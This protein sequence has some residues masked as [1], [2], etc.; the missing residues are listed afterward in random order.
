M[1]IAKTD[2][3]VP[4]EMPCFELY[5][6]YYSLLIKRINFYDSASEKNQDLSS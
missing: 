2:L 6:I 4:G 3:A 5:I 1:V